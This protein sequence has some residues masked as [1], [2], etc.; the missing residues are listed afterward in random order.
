[1]NK[2][3]IRRLKSKVKR[4]EKRI[5]EVEAGLLF[6]SRMIGT[7]F[8]DIRR[9]VASCLNGEQS[10]FNIDEYWEKIHSKEEIYV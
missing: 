4:Q 5:E 2:N 9:T 10:Y 1:M 3:E 8:P 6:L 7:C